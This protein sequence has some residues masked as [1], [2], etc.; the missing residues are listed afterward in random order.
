MIGSMVG[1]G[2]SHRPSTGSRC[3]LPATAR[4]V[5]PSGRGSTWRRASYAARACRTREKPF[6][7]VWNVPPDTIAPARTTPRSVIGTSSASR[8]TVK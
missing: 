4:E 8:C 2:S 5:R 6:I 7:A 1:S 3:G